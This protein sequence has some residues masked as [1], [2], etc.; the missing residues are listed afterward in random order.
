L[1][2]AEN[3]IDAHL[4]AGRLTDAG[5]ET[6]TVVDR[7]TPGAWLFGG[8]NPWAPVT[9]FVRRF[10]LEDARVVLAEISLG[11]DL[12]EPSPRTHRRG[13]GVLWWV[14]ALALG[15]L[16]TWMSLEHSAD[17]MERCRAT[18]GCGVEERP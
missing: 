12:P 17:V 7:V 1:F 14:L 10:Q 6:A 9:V 8:S 15:T 2:K 5:V 16:F 13:Y 4:L 11:L 3:Y 18:G